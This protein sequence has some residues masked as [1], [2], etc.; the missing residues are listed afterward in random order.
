MKKEMETLL[1]ERE[2]IETLQTQIREKKEKIAKLAIEIEAVVGEGI[3]N[4]SHE[5][6]FYQIRK[7]K[8]G[9]SYICGPRDTPF[10]SWRKK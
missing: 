5:G 4:I 1:S 3:G 9:T 8:K 7:T 10:G 2:E 6:K